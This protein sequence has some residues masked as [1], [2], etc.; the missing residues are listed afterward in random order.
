MAAKQKEW[1]LLPNLWIGKTNSFLKV[2]RLLGPEKKQEILKGWTP[3][4]CKGQVQKIKAWFKNQIALSEDQKKEFAQK[5]DNRPVEALKASTSTKYRQESP[6][7]QPEGQEKV[8]VEQALNL[9]LQNSK[10]RKDSHGQ[11]AH[12]GK[13]IDGIK[14]QQGGNNEPIF[15]KGIDL[16]KHLSTFKTFHKEGSTKF[17]NLEYVQKKLVREILQ[18]TESQ[19]IIMGLE[20]VNK[21]NIFSLT[22]ICERVESKVTLLNKTDDNCIYFIT[23]K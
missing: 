18:I 13:S 9:K 23:K 17:S 7:E 16:E 4:S 15:T 8:Q 10:E 14:E 19:K 21:Y 2:Y 20:N 1:E 22:H 5:K 11:C 12:Y 3:I 6:K